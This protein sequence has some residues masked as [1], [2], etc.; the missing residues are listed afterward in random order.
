M[1][2]AWS[3]FVI[4]EKLLTTYSGGF[5]HLYGRKSRKILGKTLQEGGFVDLGQ[6]SLTIIELHRY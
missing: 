5:N 4:L 3:L 2:I 6:G 1:L